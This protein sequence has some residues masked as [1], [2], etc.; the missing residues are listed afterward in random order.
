MYIV[1]KK[2][3]PLLPGQCL[4]LLGQTLADFKIIL[5]NIFLKDIGLK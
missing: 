1:F 2:Q 5:A 4:L 3:P